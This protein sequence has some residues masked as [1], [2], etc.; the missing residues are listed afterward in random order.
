MSHLGFRAK[1]L[2]NT[3]NAPTC[4]RQAASFRALLEQPNPTENIVLRDRGRLGTRGILGA[5][6]RPSTFAPVGQ[7]GNRATRWVVG[8]LRVRRLFRGGNPADTCRGNEV[9]SPPS[10]T[11]PGVCHSVGGG[12]V[13]PPSSHARRSFG[14]H[15]AVLRV[16]SLR[17]SPVLSSGPPP[18][19]ALLPAPVGARRFV[20]RATH[21]RG[22]V[23]VESELDDAIS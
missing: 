15:M 8:A 23:C 12:V 7:L 22:L 6:G 13:V 20:T 17:S 1:T 2:T 3:S 11:Q 18:W 9:A 5:A 19:E 4:C 16:G 10:L 14:R 21:E